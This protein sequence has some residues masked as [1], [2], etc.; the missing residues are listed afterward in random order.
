VTNCERVV[1]GDVRISID[2]VID[3]IMSSSRG[4]EIGAIVIY[5]GTVKGIS[6]GFKVHELI[7]EPYEPQT[8]KELCRIVDEWSKRDDLIDVKVI[9]RTGRLKVGE[10][11]LLIVVASKHRNIAFECAKEIIDKLKNQIPL[12]KIEVR[13]DGSYQILGDGKKIRIN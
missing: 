3:D 10:R 5:V 7:F 1:I 8:I 4:S 9:L 6:D 12:K 13:E 11:I 2:N